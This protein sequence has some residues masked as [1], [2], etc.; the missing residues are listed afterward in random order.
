MISAKLLESTNDAL[1]LP[2]QQK[3]G[4]IRESETFNAVPRYSLHK[5]V[6]HQDECFIDIL[7]KVRS[8]QFDE[9]V[10]ASI[11][12]RT[13]HKSQLP[14]SCL[15]LYTTRERVVS[16]NEKGYAEYPGEGIDFLTQDSYVG[17]KRTAKIALRE[18]KLLEHISIKPNMPMMPI[19]NLHVHTSWV[20]GTNALVECMEEE[21]ICLKKW[22]P[23]GNDAIYWI[24]RISRQ[25]SSTS[26]TRTQCPIVP[27]F[28]TTIHKA[29][30]ANIDCVGIHLNNMLSH[31]QLYVAMSCVRKMDDLYF[32]GAETPLNIKRKFGADVDALDIKV[33]RRNERYAFT[34]D[35]RA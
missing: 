10:I 21:N 26:Y 19:H 15:R 11:N 4:K 35:G 1:L 7:N 18:T 17:N 24:Q 23:N 16:A 34:A 25:V 32:F 8:Y 20:N 14:L 5:P 31:G 29:Q 13:V 9:S 27:A 6:C 3:E 30:I 2:I 28:V 22:L 12:E 33:T